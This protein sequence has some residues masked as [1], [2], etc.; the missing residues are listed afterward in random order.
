MTQ[1]FEYVQCLYYKIITCILVPVSLNNKK[2]FLYF[3]LYHTEF[4]M[5]TH[6]SFFIYFRVFIGSDEF[7]STPIV[8][9]GYFILPIYF[10][11]APS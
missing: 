1:S 11:H 3:F 5:A 8:L 4:L 6:L 10:Y 7:L 9:Y 2:T